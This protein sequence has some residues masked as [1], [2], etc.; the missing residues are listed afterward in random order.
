VRV[1]ITQR[2]KLLTTGAEKSREG[3]Y[4][5][6]LPSTKDRFK[7]PLPAFMSTA[8]GEKCGVT[9]INDA[10]V[11]TVENV[12]KRISQLNKP[13]VSFVSSTVGFYNVF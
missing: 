6:A 5:N 1:L 3:T 4:S 9:R 13:I 8:Y 2:L 7:M 10:I 12:T 11:S